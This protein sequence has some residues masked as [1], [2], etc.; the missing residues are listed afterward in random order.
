MDVVD[1]TVKV[2]WLGRRLALTIGGRDAGMIYGYLFLAGIV[3]RV[4]MPDFKKMTAEK[5]K[6]DGRLRYALSSVRTHSESIAFFGGGERERKIVWRRFLDVLKVENSKLFSDMWFGWYKELF[7]NQAPERLQQHFRF[8]FAVKQFSNDVAILSDGGA[9]LTERQHMIWGVQNTVK[10]SIRDLVQVSDK[11]E[12][13][14]GVLSRLAEL[15]LVLSELNSSSSKSSSTSWETSP[16]NG[17]ATSKLEIRNL[18]IV[19][20]TGVCVAK[21]INL[22]VTPRNR[23]LVSGPNATGKTSLFRVLAKLW[24]PHPGK[25]CMIRVN[26][27]MAFVPQRVYSVFPGS[28][29]DQITYPKKFQKNEIDE[30]LLKR[31]QDL[32]AMVGIKYLIDRYEEGLHAKRNFCDVLSLGEQQRLGMARLFFREP[33]FAILDECTDAVSVDVEERL[34]ETATKMGITVITISKRL[35]LEN[36]HEQELRLGEIKDE[37]FSL[38]EVE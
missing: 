5:N 16:Q 8:T 38:N 21:G 11:F 3:A 27:D 26:G 9:S 34:Y 19:T 35:A 32:L 29:L 6:A 31:A 20:P 37:G 2:L 22:N 1:P 4:I 7:V 18:D 33:R 12:S 23:L 25:N 17:H 36:F 28:L 13:L 14:S 10:R 24:P 30:K 15:D